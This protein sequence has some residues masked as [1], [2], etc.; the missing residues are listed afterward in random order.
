MHSNIISTLDK[1]NSLILSKDRSIAR[2]RHLNMLKAK[3]RAEISAIALNSK[4]NRL[5]YSN[6][7]L[8]DYI[9]CAVRAKIAKKKAAKISWFV[10]KNRVSTL[11]LCFL[12]IIPFFSN[13]VLHF[14]WS[15]V[16]IILLFFGRYIPMYTVED[17]RREIRRNGADKTIIK[18]NTTVFSNEEMRGLKSA[19]IFV[20]GYINKPLIKSLANAIHQNV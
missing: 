10:S 9:D 6:A 15:Y 13:I 7:P 19:H 1:D 4:A 2:N 18:L 14:M 5:D 8:E 3:R 16:I 12:I 20:N 17:L 11:K